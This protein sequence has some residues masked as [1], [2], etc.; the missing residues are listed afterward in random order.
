MFPYRKFIEPIHNEIQPSI[1][2]IRYLCV[3]ETD[4]Y[5]LG[6]FVFPPNETIPLHDHPD[7]T[8]LSRVLY[9]DLKV[10]A[11]DNISR[12]NM[13]EPDSETLGSSTSWMKR[14]V[15]FVMST[16]FALI[17][18]QKDKRQVMIRAFENHM[19]TAVAPEVT[20]LYPSMGNIHE[21]TAGERGA[22]VL[23]VLLPPYRSDHDRDCTHYEKFL[24][25]SSGPGETCWLYEIPRPEWFSCRPGTYKHL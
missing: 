3:C 13:G 9:G 18:K 2:G 14:I 19:T 16:I 20:V 7:M 4:L 24:G 10:K 17:G 6:I 25:S 23:D 12:K 21:F 15:S 1:P 5:T 8:V 11:F 22:A